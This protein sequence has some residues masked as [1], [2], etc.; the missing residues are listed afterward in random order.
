MRLIDLTGEKFGRLT[1]MHIERGHKRV[2]WRCLCNCGKAAVVSGDK[3]KSGWTKSCG[4]LH[5]EF[6]AHVCRFINR[7]HGHSSGGKLSPEYIS[8]IGMKARCRG[9]DERKARY[10]AKRGIMVCDRWK[11]SF[12]DFL[13]DMG[14]KPSPKHSIERKDNDGNYCPSNC[15]W[16]TA[17][18]Q[19][20]NRRK[21]H[22]A[23]R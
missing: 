10:Y 13:A 1:V 18:E 17:K 5:K 7:T 21:A 11:H 19:A 9:R 3:L 14:E 23:M 8:W 12:S 16:A 22:R 2:K 15:K 6:S 20:N 4:C